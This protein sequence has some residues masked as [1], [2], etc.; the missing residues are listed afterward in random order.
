[1]IERLS[2]LVYHC[3]KLANDFFISVNQSLKKKLIKLGICPI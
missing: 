3:G 1:M 2:G